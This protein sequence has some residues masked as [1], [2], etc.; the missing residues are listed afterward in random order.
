ME[1][2]ISKKQISYSKKAYFQSYK[3]KIDKI[4]NKVAKNI[5]VI[6]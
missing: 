1:M 4:Y 5:P 2:K 3:R 6:Y